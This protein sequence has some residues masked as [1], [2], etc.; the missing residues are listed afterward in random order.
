M[1]VAVEAKAVVVEEAKA[2]V[3]EE[4]KAAAEEEDKAAAVVERAQAT[5]TAQE[6]PHV[7]MGSAA[8]QEMETGTLVQ[9]TATAVEERSVAKASA[10]I[11]MAKVELAVEVEAARAKAEAGVKVKVKVARTNAPVTATVPR[12]FARMESASKPKTPRLSIKTASPLVRYEA[13]PPEPPEKQAACFSH[14]FSLRESPSTRRSPQ[15]GRLFASAKSFITQ[16]VEIKS[17]IAGIH[18]QSLPSA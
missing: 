5:A 16:K 4:A 3:V 15:G 17:F 10:R 8:T 2:A 12:A 7:S 13:L 18:V 14:L 9:A 6:T 11:R 1:V